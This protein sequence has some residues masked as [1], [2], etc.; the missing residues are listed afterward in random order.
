MWPGVQ[1]VTPDVAPGQGLSDLDSR[2]QIHNLVVCFYRDVVADDL[3]GPVF[4]EVAEVDWAVHIP[5]LI[6]FWCR[7]LLGHPGYDGYILG[8]HQEVHHL[9]AFRG[10]LFDRWYT[11]FVAAV[12]EG[13]RGPFAETAKEHAARIAAVLAR[14]LTGEAWEAPAC[15]TAG[16]EGHFTPSGP[17]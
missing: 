16:V 5:K 11:L 3:L 9:E 4:N 2:T 17:R 8:A 15:P 6:D 1:P 10:E 12:D 14:R 13:W 7:V